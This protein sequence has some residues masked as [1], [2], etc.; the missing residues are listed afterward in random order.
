MRDGRSNNNFNWRRSTRNGANIVGQ[1][2]HE[3]DLANDFCEGCPSR[4]LQPGKFPGCKE[5]VST[6]TMV[7]AGDISKNDIQPTDDRCLS[8]PNHPNNRER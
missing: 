3:M 7:R 2:S 5:G 8:H 6:T 1:F 4:I